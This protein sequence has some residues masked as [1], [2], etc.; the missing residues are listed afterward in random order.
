[1]LDA[2]GLHRRG[3]HQMRHTFASLLKVYAHWLPH[4]SKEHSSANGLARPVMPAS[5]QTEQTSRTECA[6]RE[7]PQ[8]LPESRLCV[9]DKS[10]TPP[11]LRRAMSIGGGT[12]I[13]LP[14]AVVWACAIFLAVA[15]VFAGLL[16]LEGPS[17]IRWSEV[18]A[19]GL[20]GK[21]FTLSSECWKSWVASV[22]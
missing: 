10:T 19:L 13:T 6:Q 18:R 14:R 17:A 20:S 7:S 3:P 5:G 9:G 22:C 15:F 16:K 21:T 12:V 1:M 2:A 11:A 8:S 4:A